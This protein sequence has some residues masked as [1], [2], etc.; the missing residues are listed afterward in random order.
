MVESKNMFETLAKTK[1]VGVLLLFIGLA[2]FFMPL[3]YLVQNVSSI[4]S[5]PALAVICYIIADIAEIVAAVIFWVIAAK[6]LTTKS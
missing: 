1:I 5:E 4:G 6:I 3:A 2:F